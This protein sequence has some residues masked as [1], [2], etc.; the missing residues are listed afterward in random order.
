MINKKLGRGFCN[1]VN[2]KII[3]LNNNYKKEKQT[4]AIMDSMDGSLDKLP[5]IKD[6][7]KIKDIIEDWFFSL[8]SFV[9]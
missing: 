6:P 2:A 8:K 5:E 3:E 4:V 1:T 7:Y 9:I